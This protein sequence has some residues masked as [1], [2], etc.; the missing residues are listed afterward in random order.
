MSEEDEG[1]D[2]RRIVANPVVRVKLLFAQN[3]KSWMI[4]AAASCLAF[5]V[6]LI[7]PIWVARSGLSLLMIM[8]VIAALPRNRI[9]DERIGIWPSGSLHERVVSDD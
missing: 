2:R 5:Y 9:G 1:A 7:V 6:S 4:L 3:W 8:I